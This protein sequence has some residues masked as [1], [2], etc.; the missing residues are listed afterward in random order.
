MESDLT[1]FEQ[2]AFS[3]GFFLLN[4]NNGWNFRVFVSSV[5]EFP[6]D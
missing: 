4:L 5:D 1:H 3:F 2:I 6:S